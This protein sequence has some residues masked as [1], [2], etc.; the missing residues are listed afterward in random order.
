MGFT[1][2]GALFKLKRTWVRVVW[3]LRG[4]WAGLHWAFQGCWALAGL[5]GRWAAYRLLLAGCDSAT[6]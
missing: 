6:Q 1:G 3:P 2:A 5:L 4:T